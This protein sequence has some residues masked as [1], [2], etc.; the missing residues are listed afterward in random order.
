[1]PRIQVLELPVGDGDEA[2]PFILVIDQAPYDGPLYDAFHRDLA[3][4]DF[5]AR[6]GARAVLCFE[7]TI[8][9]P[10]NEAPADGQTYPITFQVL[11][12]FT[13]FRAQVADELKTTQERLATFVRGQA[14]EE[15]RL[16]AQHAVSAQPDPRPT[17]E[18]INAYVGGDRI[19]GRQ[20]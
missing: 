5:V 16:A 3:A 13:E 11:P 15:L 6:T 18:E 4:N 10:A 20:A 12:D 9:I 8:D 14:D 19:P 1:M 17:P 7:G 2:P